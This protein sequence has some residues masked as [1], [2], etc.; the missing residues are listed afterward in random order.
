MNIQIDANYPGG[1]IAVHSIEAGCVDVEQELRDTTRWWFYWNFRMHADEPGDVLIRFANGDV[2]GPWGPAYSKDGIHWEWLGSHA[3]QSHSS[4]R[5]RIEEPNQ[6]VYFAY[7]LPYQLQHLEA[8]MQSLDPPSYTEMT[9]LVQSEQGRPI[10]L[11]TFGRADARRDIVLTARHHACES[12]ASYLLEGVMAYLASRSGSTFMDTHR[13][14]CVPMIDLDGVENGDQGKDRSPHDHNR[15]YTNNPLYKPTQALMDYARDLNVILHIDFHCPYL[16]GERNDYPFFV[17]KPSEV[18]N[19]NIM[20]FGQLLLWQ[21]TGEIQYDP[22]KDIMFGE[23]WNL[24]TVGKCSDFFM[25][26]GTPLTT[27]L[28]FPYFGY[29]EGLWTTDQI[30][31]FGFCLGETIERFLS[32]A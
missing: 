14:H 32:E 16:W 22:A 23:D 28:E 15:D 8:F 31:R 9:S 11:I 12:T 17:H 20:R 18:V 13:V 19:G 27:T 4:F 24:S 6:Q 29:R 30:K 5:Y 25:E 2:V 3:L 10:P 7:S 1:N 21:A 26:L